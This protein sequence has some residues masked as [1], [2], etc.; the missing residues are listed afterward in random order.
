MCK[1]SENSISNG[2]VDLPRRKFI[3]LLG[4]ALSIPLGLRADEKDPPPK[5]RNVISA[6]EALDRLMIGNSRYL[7]GTRRRYDFASQ[8]ASLTKGQNPFAG[9][10]SCADSRV[11]PEYTFDTGLGDLFV[12]RVAGNFANDDTIAS[13]EYAVSVLSTPLIFVRR[14]RCNG[15]AHKRWNFISRSYSVTHRCPHT[16]RQFRR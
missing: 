9:I 3:A 6:D 7:S 12:C 4:G 11:G 10:L 1:S 15:Q 8:R 16:C 13:F 2:D 14:G 5:R